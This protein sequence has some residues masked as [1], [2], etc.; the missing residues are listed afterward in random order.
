M[1]PS[2]TLETQLTQLQILK[3]TPIFGSA[4]IRTGGPHDDR[5]DL[6][7]EDM[8]SR[9]WNGVIPTWRVF[10]EPVPTEHNRVRNGGGGGGG[11][12]GLNPLNWLQQGEGS[13]ASEYITSFIREQ[14]RRGGGDG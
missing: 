11:G 6:K 1:I 12:L 3:I 2:F 7:D 5:E 8:R 14:N 4:K 13:K 10:G 9:V